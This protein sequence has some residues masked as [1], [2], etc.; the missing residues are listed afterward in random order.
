[1]KRAAF[2]HLILTAVVLALVAPG[3][4]RNPKALTPIPGQGT[5]VGP[6]N[7]IGGGQPITDG[8]GFGG[9][10]IGAADRGNAMKLLDPNFGVQDRPALA[11]YTVYF[12]FDSSV[13]K[14]GEVS[15]IES[16]AGVLKSNPDQAV[17]IEGHCDERGTL[18]YNRALGERRAQSVR[19]SLVQMGVGAERIHT[20]SYGEDVPAVDAHNE[21]AWSKNRRGEFVLLKP[22]S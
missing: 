10:G 16:V 9:E 20:I 8:T 2:L 6:N 21:A 3:C 13:V 15:K 4:S 18:E 17:I 11:A 22:K 14:P 5:G 7:D 19:E 12:D 1:M